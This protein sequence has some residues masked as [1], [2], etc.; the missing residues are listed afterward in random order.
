MVDDQSFAVESTT[1]PKLAGDGTHTR[2]HTST[3]KDRHPSSSADVADLTTAC[4]SAYMA[5]WLQGHSRRSTPTPS[6]MCSRSSHTQ[7]SEA[8]PCC[9]SSI[10]QATAPAGSEATQKSQ[11]SAPTQS[12]P[13]ARAALRLARVRA[14]ALVSPRR[15]IRR[16]TLRTAC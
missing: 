7:R 11:A 1:L 13:P 6:L 2:T 5:G 4:V 10:C 14:R 16:P 12:Q 8:L 9:R 15:W 3:H